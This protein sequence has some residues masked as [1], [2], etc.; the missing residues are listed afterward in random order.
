V[1]SDSFLSQILPKF[2]C[3]P[4][5]TSSYSSVAELLEFDENPLL[6]SENA[7][8][9]ELEELE[10]YEI[11]L[12][13]LEL[14]EL[15]PVG[16][17]LEEFELSGYGFDELDD[18]DH[19]VPLELED[20]ED[21]SLNCMGEKVFKSGDRVFARANCSFLHGGACQNPGTGVK[22]SRLKL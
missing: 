8:L 6:D 14:D 13:E 5:Q 1:P 4:L 21:M 9:V 17:E 22:G 3:V 19:E 12:E 7:E 18:D 11:S 15:G 16:L 20:D 2:F 10:L